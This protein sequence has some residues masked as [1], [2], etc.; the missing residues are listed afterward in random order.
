MSRPQAINERVTHFWHTRSLAGV[1]LP[2]AA[3]ERNLNTG[4]MQR[5]MGLQ[6]VRSGGPFQLQT[7]QARA[8][9]REVS[10]KVRT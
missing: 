10:G 8:S 3:F 9:A 1:R 5:R 4:G 2:I 6:P 7:H